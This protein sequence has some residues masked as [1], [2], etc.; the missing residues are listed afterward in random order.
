MKKIKRLALLATVIF[1]AQAQSAYAEWKE[2]GS[3]DVMTVYVDLDTVSTYFELTQI[4]SMLDFK[5]PGVNPENKI[6]SAFA[7]APLLYLTKKDCCA[8]TK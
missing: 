1:F 6:L 5:K 8:L 4:V 7:A 2:L 3:N